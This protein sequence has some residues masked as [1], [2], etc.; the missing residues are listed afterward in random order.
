MGGSLEPLQ[1]AVLYRDRRRRDQ[2]FGDGLFGEPSWDIMLDL[3]R[4]YERDERVSVTSACIAA[5]CPSTT[6]LRHLARLECA[7]LIERYPDTTDT[8]RVFVRLSELGRDRMVKT[9]VSSK[10]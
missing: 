10:R 6:A 4:A 8:R 2:I 7:G 9:L 3:Y 1:A 5:A